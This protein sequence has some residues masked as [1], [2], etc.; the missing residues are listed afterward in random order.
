MVD[1]LPLAAGIITSTDNDSVSINENNVMYQVP[2]IANATTY[3]WTYSGTGVAFVGGNITTTNSV[4]INFAN[5]ATSGDLTV[6]GNNACGD[7][8]VSANYAIWVSPV[9]IGENANSLNCKIYPNPTKGMITIAIDGINSS[10]DLQI[11][12][13]QGKVIRT[14]KLNN[15]YPSYSQDIDLSTYSKGIYFVKLIS[16]DFIKVEKVVLQ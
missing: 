13:I 7:G 12:N 11:V 6:V 5:D 14:E 15:Q 8:A 4:T 2:V 3:T 9:G 16:K 1:P 10:L